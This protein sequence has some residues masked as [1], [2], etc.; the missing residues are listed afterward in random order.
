MQMSRL[1]EDELTVAH[2][3]GISES[4]IARKAAG[5]T[6]RTVRCK[7][8]KSSRQERSFRFQRRS[9]LFFLT[10][11][12]GLLGG[13]TF[14]LVLKKLHFWCLKNYIFGV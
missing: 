11:S 4:F 12:T 10:P 1:D 5:Q 2:L 9:V 13:R 8:D 6:V 7:C 3:V 14:I